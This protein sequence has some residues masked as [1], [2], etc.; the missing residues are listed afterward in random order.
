MKPGL[1]LIFLMALAPVPVCGF[2]LRAE[3][4]ASPTLIVGDGKPGFSD[5]A[6]VRFHKPIRLAPYG[7]DAILVADIYNHALRV[8]TLDGRVKTIAGG[9]LK[10][11]HRDGNAGEAR[12]DSPHG[13]AYDPRSGVI[14]LAEAGNHT[15]RHLV[16]VSR[17]E[18][19]FSRSYTV[20]TMA[21]VPGESGF[22]DGPK[23]AALFSSPHAVVALPSGGIVVADIGNARIR[24]IEGGRVR[25]LAGTGEVGQAD[26]EPIEATFHYPMDIARTDDRT[27][28][29]ADAGS[30]RIR[31]LVIGESVSTMQVSSELHTPHG[32]S[33]DGE[34]VVYVADMDA[35]RVVSVDATGKVTPVFGTGEGGSEPHEL[36]R[37][38]AVLVHAGHLWIADLDNHQVKAIPVDR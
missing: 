37:P 6:P 25:T 26:G 13:V 16:P 32:I 14:F 10:K 38:A 1:V 21:G 2:G 29:I 34:G 31:R 7:D 22:K 18:P 30:H 4:P 17:D 24:L 35:H 11:G 15:I 12:F 9:P 36:N 33:V 27:V 28:L 8:V 5:A 19:L 3:E 20:S 23:E